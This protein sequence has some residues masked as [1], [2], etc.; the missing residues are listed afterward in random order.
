MLS[1]S[2]LFLANYLAY[3]DVLSLR[4]AADKLVEKREEL[5]RELADLERRLDLN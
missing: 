5:E 3:K 2:D 1:K 4:V